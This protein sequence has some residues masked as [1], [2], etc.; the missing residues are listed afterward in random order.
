MQ[1][2]VKKIPKKPP[3]DKANNW[4]LNMIDDKMSNDDERKRE[5]KADSDLICLS[6]MSVYDILLS[7]MVCHFCLSL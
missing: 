7:N 1:S 5:K 6:K 4:K 3:Q 2:K